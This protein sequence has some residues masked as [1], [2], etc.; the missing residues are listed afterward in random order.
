MCPP[1][2]RF[3][4]KEGRTRSPQ[5]P[6][7]G[8]LPCSCDTRKRVGEAQ[9][10]Q[11]TQPGKYQGF[12]AL[13]ESAIRHNPF[14]AST[15]ARLRQAIHQGRV[16]G[17]AACHE[18]AGLIRDVAGHGPTCV[19]DGCGQDVLQ[20]CLVSRLERQGQD[21]P[22]QPLSAQ[23]LGRRCRMKR[24]RLPRLEQMRNHVPL[25]CQRSVPI[26]GQASLL[27]QS[28]QKKV[29]WSNIPR[30]PPSIRKVQAQVGKSPQVQRHIPRPEKV[31]V[32]LRNQRGALPPGGH[33]QSP[34]IVDNRQLKGLMQGGTTTQLKCPP[35]CRSMKHCV[36]MRPHHMGRPA[37]MTG[38]PRPYLGRRPCRP[39]LVQPHEVFRTAFHR[40]PQG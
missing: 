9:P 26:H 19:C 6:S 8:G 36:T 33:V 14:D 2:P 11:Q 31:P 7:R 3:R 37:P 18:H 15:S 39:G 29:G 20:P 38:Q 12:L 40:T 13:Y 16:E 32:R 10:S 24:K 25:T 28:V 35:L 23:T 17:P 22:F 21:L 30:D 34:Q 1:D 5:C 27:H 4:S